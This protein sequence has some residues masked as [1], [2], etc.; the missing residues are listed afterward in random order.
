M[1]QINVVSGNQIPVSMHQISFYV[2]C[3]KASLDTSTLSYTPLYSYGSSVMNHIMPYC[4]YI[5][6]RIYSASGQHK[7]SELKA[8]SQLSQ[9]GYNEQ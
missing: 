3:K 8:S 5:Y 4:D 9:M 2:I 1:G 7:D 6:W